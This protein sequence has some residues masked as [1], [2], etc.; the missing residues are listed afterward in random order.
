MQKI[1]VS[2]PISEIGL[3]KLLTAEDIKVDIKTG[4]KPEE[5]KQLISEYHGLMVRS[6]TKVTREILEAAVNLKVIG[7]AGVGVDNIDLKRATEL[8][9]VVLNAPDGNTISTAEHT[10][11]MLISMARWIPQAD[12]D[13]KQ[14][15]W[16]R[17]K[18]VGVELNRKVLGIIGLGR[19]GAELAI[20]AKA[21]NMNIIAYDPYT[22][23]ERAKQLGVELTTIDEVLEKADFLTVHTPLTKET[24]YLIAERE[25]ALMKKGVRLL[26]CARGGIIKETALLKALEDGIVAQAALDVFEEE[27]PTENRLINNPNVITTPHLGAS[28]KEAQINVAIDVAEE[29][30]NYLK[31]KPFK[32][33]VN[34]PALNQELLNH[35]QPYLKLGELIGI[36]LANY[37]F[38]AIEKIEIQFAGDIID[39]EIDILARNVLKGILSQHLGSIGIVND[40]NAPLLAKARGIEVV[41]SRLSK[42]H[43]YTNLITVKV[44]TNYEEKYIAGTLLNGYG[45]RIVNLNGYTVDLIPEGKLLIFDHFDQP[46]IIGQFGTILGKA[47]IN[48]ATMQVGR[49]KTGGRA[50][51]ILRLDQAVAEEILEELKG[52]NGIENIYQ[53]EL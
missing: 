28:T 18:Y 29:L 26:N 35:V 27:P 9:I 2:D 30:Y 33:A 46:G 48:I 25:F 45:A 32:N 21:F 42:S 47:K 22:T 53:V 49:K 24:K 40:V 6:E 43:G 17:K 19:I 20:R 44:K 41:E 15:V 37:L 7:R 10:F 36:I 14:G 3:K 8:G 39:R 12:H 38:G 16:N 23:E 51:A 50:I 34:L 1:L 31:G 52:I 13:L 4:L 5:L 11:A